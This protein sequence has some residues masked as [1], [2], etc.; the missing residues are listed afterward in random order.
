MTIPVDPQLKEH[1]IEQH[2]RYGR[3]L[4]S[5]EDEYGY[6][7]SIIGRW[8]KN[9]QREATTNAVYLS[10]LVD[11]KNVFCD[12]AFSKVDTRVFFSDFRFR[13]WTQQLFSV[14]IHLWK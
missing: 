8:C 11:T 9:F 12:I 13:L 2:L 14:F 3:T 10:S 1:I 7:R 6:S 4:R 5:L